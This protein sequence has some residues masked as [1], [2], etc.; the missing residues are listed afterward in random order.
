M[1]EISELLYKSIYLLLPAYFANMA[2]VL[3][4]NINFLNYPL[5]F[6]KKIGQ[7]KIF[8]THK[9]WRGLFFGILTAIFA[10]FAQSIF[11]RFEVFSDISLIDF[12]KNSFILI[13]FLMG[14]GSIFGDAVKSFFKRKLNIKEGDPLIFFDQI[15]FIIGAFAFLA[16]IYVPPLKI[17]ITGTVI[18]VL[19]HF[20]SNCIGYKLKLKSVWW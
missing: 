18:T 8:G 11:Y 19:L 20:I 7:T 1:M 14:F 16:I 2:P 3:F 13:G 4:K 17:I 12:N 9:T 5:D 6:N 15:D 10:A